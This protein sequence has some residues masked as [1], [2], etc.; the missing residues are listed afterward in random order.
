MNNMNKSN[1]ILKSMFK[2]NINKGHHPNQTMEINR[3]NRFTPSKKPQKKIFSINNKGNINSNYERIKKYQ[4]SLQKYNINNMIKSS[5]NR[6]NIDKNVY[7]KNMFNGSNIPNSYKNNPN[8]SKTINNSKN[9][10]Y[11]TSLQKKM[12]SKSYVNL[13]QNNIYNNNEHIPHGAGLTISN[14]IYEKIYDF[15][16]QNNNNSNIRNNDNNSNSNEYKTFVSEVNNIINV[17][18]NYINIIKKEYEKII[19][20]KVQNKDK[21][22]SKLKTEKEYLI[23]ENKDLKYKIIEMFYCIKRYEN[24][25][26]KN[27]DKNLKYIK[28]LINENIYLRNCT[29]KTNNIN[30]SYFAQLENDIRNQISQKELLIQKKMEEEKNNQNV[31]IDNINDNNKDKEQNNDN[32]K[33]PFLTINNNSGNN[34]SSKINHKRQRTQFKLG[35]PLKSENNNKMNEDEKLNNN[36]DVLSEYINVIKNNTLLLSKAENSSQ[37]NLLIG[38]KNNENVNEDKIKKEKIDNNNLSIESDTDTIVHVDN[39]IESIN[40]KTCPNNE[41]SNTI[42]DTTNKILQGIHYSSPDDKYIKRIEF[43]K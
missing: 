18:L 4:Q 40:N 23:K 32:D 11:N 34:L 27:K 35:F 6:K 3:S 1:G 39:S 37:K 24:N 30:K 7:F 8:N 13:F 5:K 41:N 14:S 33:N 36:R 9:K 2:M 31:K 16:I 20:K 17:L 12:G 42:K 29:D 19:V 43:T 22:I 21:E 25:K 26:D 15:E 10:N 28:L 38:K